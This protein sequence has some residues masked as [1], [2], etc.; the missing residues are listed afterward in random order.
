MPENDE[1]H[2]GGKAGPYGTPP[3]EEEPTKQVEHSDNGKNN[4][5]DDEKK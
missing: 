1:P 5:G 3:K 2:N 4:D